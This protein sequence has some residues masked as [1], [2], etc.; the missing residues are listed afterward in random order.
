MVHAA[1]P[2]LNP[3]TQRAAQSYDVLVSGGGPSGLCAALEAAR[4]SLRVRVVERRPDLQSRGGG[5]FQPVVLDRQTLVNLANLRVDPK[6][7]RAQPISRA[8]FLGPAG[9]F[10]G[11]V[12]YPEM[13]GTLSGP[14]SSTLE[15]LMFRRDLVA[16]SAIQ[17]VERSLWE[18]CEAHPNIEVTFDC[19]ISALRPGPHGVE[20]TLRGGSGEASTCSAR[21]LAIADG[22]WSDVK[23]AMRLAGGSKE[24]RTRPV[25]LLA[26]RFD[27]VGKPG[28]LIVRNTPGDPYQHIV[29]LSLPHELVLYLKAP[30]NVDPGDPSAVERVASE[31]IRS[32]GMHARLSDAPLFFTQTV[33]RADS[34]VLGDRIF[35]LG[36]AALSG[37]AV[38]GVYLNK[39]IFDAHAF[40]QVC[41][42]D[43]TRPEELARAARVFA[44][45]HDSAACVQAIL[46]EEVV[47]SVYNT[48]S[49]EALRDPLSQSLYS[50][51][52]R[53]AFRYKLQRGGL[54]RATMLNVVD[55]Y[56]TLAYA[57]GEAARRQSAP[58]AFRGFRLAGDLWHRVQQ[59]VE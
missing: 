11:S 54:G 43:P 31:A 7:L 19:V 28:E 29:A 47:S 5:R 45:R 39:A 50:L 59:A 38:L 27:P 22:A 14:S 25:D 42:A 26:C 44:E 4:S 35:V 20:L 18:Q 32:V 16:V 33:R 53:W 55:A 40:G 21:I 2:R 37:T 23:G 36:D 51:G 1:P 17:D 52:P 41:A 49:S 8:V 48:R 30:A 12:A 24:S 6:T 10:E 34:I 58:Y 57:F 15:R 56:A 3:R 13:S 9:D 46:E